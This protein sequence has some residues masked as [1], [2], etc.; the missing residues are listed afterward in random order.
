[1]KKFAVIALTAGGANTARRLCKQ[2]A[3]QHYQVE[4][5]LPQRLADRAEHSYGHGKFKATMQQLFNKYDCV[6]C[7]MA[8]G[9]VVRALTGVI[10]DKTVDP[11]VIVMDEQAHHV[12]S[13]LSGHVGGAN[14]W[15]RLI[16][17]LMAAEPVITTA[18]DTEQVQSIDILAKQIHGWYPNFKANTKFI[19]RCLA[20]GKRVELYLE[21]DLKHYLKQFNGFTL[22]DKIEQHQSNSPL[23]VVSDHTGFAKNADV[24]QIVPRI[25]VLGI[26]CRKNVTDGMM[27]Q[28]FTE[29]CQ[30]QQLLW[31][32]FA[33][34]VSIDIK[35]HEAAIQYLARTLN[36]E[37]EFYS[38]QEL[39]TAS[40]HYP[41]SA[42]VLKT[43]DV[44]NVACAAADFASG[45]RTIASR[46]ANHEIT[47]AYSHLHEL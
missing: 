3:T 8:T 21:P 6:V 31:Q 2:L 5:V 33:K 44:G 1:M 9:I 7:V 17:R 25:N 38:A 32:S 11:A 34:V 14:E 40:H 37:L 30:Q 19:N 13:L 27:Q 36:T 23:V 18:T 24:V 39:A 26:G 46:Y 29:F 22:L 47:M 41:S 28:T 43:V 10:V 35:K 45:E 15:T 42:F 16:A 12:I 20:E 4:L